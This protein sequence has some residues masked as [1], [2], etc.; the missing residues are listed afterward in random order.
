MLTAIASFLK[1]AIRMD[2][3]QDNEL[4][5]DSDWLWLTPM[6]RLGVQSRADYELAQRLI[7]E[8]KMTKPCTPAASSRQPLP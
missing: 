2:G 7:A 8:R 4:Q 6:E 5:P 3:I 1:E